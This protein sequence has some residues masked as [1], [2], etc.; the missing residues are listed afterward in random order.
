MGE[1]TRTW[2]PREEIKR[3]EAEIVFLRRQLAMVTASSVNTRFI[4]G[5]QPR[6]DGDNFGSEIAALKEYRRAKHKDRDI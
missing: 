3:L 1:G 5:R 6:R 4:A 2:D